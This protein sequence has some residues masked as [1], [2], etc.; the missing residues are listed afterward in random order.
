[1]IRGYTI[2]KNQ[3]WFKAMKKQN[4]K[5]GRCDG[6]IS[7]SIRVAQKK[8]WLVDG[9]GYCGTCSRLIKDRRKKKDE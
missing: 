1:M 6:M 7:A 8:R 2:D 9:V 3:E 4:Y 5:C